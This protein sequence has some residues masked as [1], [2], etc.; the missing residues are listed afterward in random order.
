MSPTL[1]I[2]RLAHGE[3]LP[4]P[5]YETKGAAGM[6]LRAA[7]PDDAPIT[8]R[9]GDRDMVPTGFCIAVPAGFEA[10]VRALGQ[11]PTAVINVATALAERPR[12]NRAS[13]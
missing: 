10:Q 4:L 7:P 6:D 5:A 13:S 11:G 3:G 2:Q 12:E 1:R 8:L 9:P